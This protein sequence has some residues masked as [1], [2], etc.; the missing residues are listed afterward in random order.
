MVL[1]KNEDV[2]NVANNDMMSTTSYNR[3]KVILK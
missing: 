1:Y 2:S 3:K